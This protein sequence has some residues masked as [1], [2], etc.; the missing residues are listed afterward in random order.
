MKKR[1]FLE[2]KAPLGKTIKTPKGKAKCSF[3]QFMRNSP[4]VAL[5]LDLD[6]DRNRSSIR[7]KYF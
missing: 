4:L 3:V 1:F 7:N 5:D 6:L 2:A